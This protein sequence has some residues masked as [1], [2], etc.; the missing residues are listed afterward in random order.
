MYIVYIYIKEDKM[1]HLLNDLY[2]FHVSQVTV[3]CDQ[4]IEKHDAIV[5]V[6]ENLLKKTFTCKKHMCQQKMMF[7]KRRLLWN[8]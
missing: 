4:W 1:K 2:L 8:C 7:A 3:I 5:F 6:K